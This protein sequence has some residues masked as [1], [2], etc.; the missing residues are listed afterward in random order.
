[1]KDSG[2]EFLD[3]TRFQGRFEAFILPFKILQ[4][5][6]GR[7]AN[8][9]PESAQGQLGLSETQRLV[10]SPP[11]DCSDSLTIQSNDITLSPHAWA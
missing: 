10:A 11:P 4:T 1:M 5:A 6:H 2:Y 9:I 3:F 8:V 7:V